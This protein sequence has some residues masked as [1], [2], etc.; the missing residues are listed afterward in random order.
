[1]SDIYIHCKNDR[2]LI[3]NSTMLESMEWEER[4]NT[5]IFSSTRRDYS[6]TCRTNLEYGEYPVETEVFTGLVYKLF[7]VKL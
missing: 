2:H 5:L 3:L 6:V 4:T 7:G 1:M